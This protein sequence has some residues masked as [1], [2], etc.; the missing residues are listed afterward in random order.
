MDRN[1]NAVNYG[2]NA[3]WTCP[4]C[5]KVNNGTAKFCS[6]CGTQMQIYNTGY[7]SRDTGMYGSEL[8]G[9]SGGHVAEPPKRKSGALKII[10][11]A[12]GCI[13][14]AV[15]I[16][17][18]VS[19]FLL[20]DDDDSKS[21][22]KETEQSTEESSDADNE[23][24]GNTDSDYNPNAAKE[25]TQ[26][27]P[28][29]GS[30]YVVGETYTVVGKGG[31]KVRSTPEAVANNGNQL[32]RSE[33]PSTYYSQ[34]QDAPLACLKEGAQ[35]TCLEMQGDWMRIIDGGWICVQI[36]GETLVK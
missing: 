6:G 8:Y 34:S 23:G 30:G 26:V 5:G 4:N 10:L 1:T 17:F 18:G 33:L 28:S 14:L 36:P 3:G 12:L 9:A 24:A 11:L 27:A 20:L 2:S 31:V 25:E 13:V 22:D 35:V 32:T 29:S 7:I 15:G 16:G 19:H 21:S